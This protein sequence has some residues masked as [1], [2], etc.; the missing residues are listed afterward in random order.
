MKLTEEL[1]YRFQRILEHLGD[2]GGHQWSIARHLW[3]WTEETLI[4][5]IQGATLQLIILHELH[6]RVREAQR[7]VWRRFRTGSWE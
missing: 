2:I 1:N 6:S 4:L 3:R 7:R 5:L